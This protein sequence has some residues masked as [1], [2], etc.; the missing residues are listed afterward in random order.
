MTNINT[1]TLKVI[2]YLCKFTGIIN[3]S[4]V[5]QSDGLL[6]QSTESVY[7]CLE[8]SRMIMLIIF[9]YSLYLNINYIHVMHLFKL[10]TI[11]IASRISETRLIQ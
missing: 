5:L 3:M 2:L 8:I 1:K 9:T 10:W 11:I 7:K 4:Y 6:I